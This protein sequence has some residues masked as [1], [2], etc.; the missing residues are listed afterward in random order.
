MDN[1]NNRQVVFLREVP[2]P[3]VMG[4]DGHYSAGAVIGQHIIRHEYGQFGIVHGVNSREAG[5]SYAGF[6]FLVGK[7]LNSGLLFSLRRVIVQFAVIFYILMK[8][9]YYSVLRGNNHEGGTEK[10]VGPGGKYFYK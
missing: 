6:I 3:L 7:A 8:L 10:R 4:R 5:D 9:F 2:V 1:F